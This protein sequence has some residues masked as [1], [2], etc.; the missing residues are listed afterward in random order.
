MGLGH[1]RHPVC[2]VEFFFLNLALLECQLKTTV[3]DGITIRTKI[4]NINLGDN[5]N[6]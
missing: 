5:V 2:I 6:P 1:R 4:C 3:I